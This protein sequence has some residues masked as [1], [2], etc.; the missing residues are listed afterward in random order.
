MKVRLFC[1]L[2]RCV[3]LVLMCVFFRV[4]VR[5]GEWDTRSQVD[6]LQGVCSEPPQDIPVESTIVHPGYSA[7]SRDQKDDLAL[8]RLSRT[9]TYSGKIVFNMI[10]YLPIF[11]TTLKKS[12]F[13]PFSNFHPTQHLRSQ[14]TTYFVPLKFFGHSI[15]RC[16]SMSPQN[17][18]FPTIIL[19]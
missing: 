13:Q 12:Y 19:H 7:S 18:I 8:V 1:N 4:S 17:Q 6:C 11:F 5:L 2:G 3:G 14:S 9:V 15:R 10:R 16:T